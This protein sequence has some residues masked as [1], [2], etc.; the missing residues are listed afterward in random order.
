MKRYLTLIIIGSIILSSMLGGCSEAKNLRLFSPPRTGADRQPPAAEAARK[1]VLNPNE[2]IVL[3]FYT[4]SQASKN[5]VLKNI[6]N[7]DEVAFFW[8]S[9][10][11]TGTIKRTGNIDLNLKETVQKNG[12]KAFALVHNLD[13]KGF[14][15]Q[16]AHQVLANKTIRSDFIR[17]LVALTVKENWDG[18]A[19]DIEKIP[20]GDRQAYSDFLDELHTSLKDKDKILNVS[21]PAKYQDV[22]NDLWSGGFDYAAIGKS[23]DQVVL[24]TYEEHGVGTTQGPIAS[25]GWVNRVIDFAQDRIPKQKIIMGLPVYASDW[26]SNKPTFPDYLTYA[27][28]LALARKLGV[29]VLYDETQQVPHYAYTVAG[30]RHE[31]YLEDVRS[32]SAKLGYAKKSQLHGVAI[33]RLGIE[34]PTLW[35]DVLKGYNSAQQ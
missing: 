32:L 21:I 10:N 6:K 4:D 11:G 17:N 19:V 5:S 16:L 15:S 7:L 34:D 24:M 22:P 9:F 13:S 14:N 3:G 23:A 25:Q 8:Y 28:A 2:H 26:A 35:T 29:S 1:N 30:V 12:A 20:A 27:K 31:V 33:W 18:L